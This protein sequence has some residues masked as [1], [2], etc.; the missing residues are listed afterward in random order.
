MLS[1][2]KRPRCCKGR[3]RYI[4]HQARMWTRKRSHGLRHHTQWASWR[5]SSWRPHMS[6]LKGWCLL[7]WV[8][9]EGALWWKYRP[10]YHMSCSLWR[11]GSPWL[12]WRASEGWVLH[13]GGVS[14]GG[15]LILVLIGYLSS[16]ATSPSSF[17][18][19]CQNKSKRQKITS[20]HRT[21]FSNY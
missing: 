10:M 16:P 6:H 15:P 1:I 20:L 12:R 2:D 9:Y 19:T 3:H 8:A 14:A 17:P 18:T 4:S 13:W 7:G 21:V 5:Y 11:Q